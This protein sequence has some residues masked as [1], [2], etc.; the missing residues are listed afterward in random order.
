MSE[1]KQFKGSKNQV[2]YISKSK[3]GNS[4]LTVEQD[5]TLKAG[6]KLILKKPIENLEGLL[7]AGII[8]EAKFEE[9]AAKIPEWKLSEVTKMNFKD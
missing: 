6:D 1:V 5:I 2:G 9:R 3:T 4:I 7:K 8:D